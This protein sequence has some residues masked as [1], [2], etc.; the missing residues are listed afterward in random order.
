MTVRTRSP[1]PILFIARPRWDLTGL[2]ANLAYAKL[3]KANLGGADLTDV[4]LTDVDLKGVR[5]TDEQ[6]RSVRALPAAAS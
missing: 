5:L 4:D 6:Q 1:V 2:A 3:F